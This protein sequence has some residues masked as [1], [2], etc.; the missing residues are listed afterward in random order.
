MNFADK[1]LRNGSIFSIDSDNKRINGQAVAIK[2]GL[3]AK[4]GTDEEIK[5]YIGKDTEVIDCN[6]SSI[7]PGLCDAHCHPSIASSAYSGCDLFGIY[8][9]DGQTRE[10]VMKQYLNRLRKFVSEHP[11]D[12][13]IRGT[14]WVE[15]NFPADKYPTRQELDSVC[16]DRP[17]IL[18]AF[19]QHNL[20]VNTKAI[21]MAGLDENTPEPSIGKIYR[22]ENGYPQGVFND[23][24]AMAPIKAIPGYDFS[25]KKYKE[26]FLYYQK[27]LANKYGVT[28]VQDCMHSD[29]AKQAFKELAEEGKL[30]LRIRGVHFIEPGKAATQIP[31]AIA[32]KG[33]DNVGDDFRIDTV[34]LFVEGGFSLIGGYDEAFIKEMGLPEGYNEPLYWKDDVL[35][36]ACS[37]AM[38][39]GYS[40]HIHAMGDNSVRQA[41]D[42]LARAYDKTGIKCRNVIAHLMMVNDADIEN[43]ARA[44]VMGNCQPRWMVYD[45]D[46]VGM[47]PLMGEERA[48]KA[49][50]LRSLLDAGIDISFGT[51]F[52]VTPPPDTMHEIQ[53]AMTRS[54]FPDAP[55][56]ERFKGQV[57]G[58]E[59][60]ATLAE[61]IK[62]LSING[63]YQMFAE[64]ITGS[65]EEGKSADLVILDADIEK[66]P[67][68][69]I[70]HIKVQKTIFKGDTVYER[71]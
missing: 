35:V 54:V 48:R 22:E 28:L 18:E 23:P 58:N 14:G 9:Q 47:T 30:T 51:D 60:P 50:P 36:D 12:E 38:K 46:I 25:V 42:C 69:E 3:I 70:Y 19:S 1:V 10:D 21:E 45:S 13:L 5:A 59:K 43:M 41:A 26:A 32:A 4:I 15:S 61:C 55:D 6:E 29:N 2:D 31:E 17:V 8:I 24:E 71:V 7:L 40:V 27:N 20:W 11:D 65:I 16:A 66:V 52:P 63:A 33:K 57:L 67:T 49:Y 44:A 64:K 39:A 62:A 53:C 37:Q 56:Y 34:K 68:N